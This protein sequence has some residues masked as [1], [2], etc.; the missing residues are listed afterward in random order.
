ML[1]QVYSIDYRRTGF[2]CDN[3]IIANAIFLYVRKIRTQFCHREDYTGVKVAIVLGRHFVHVA[4]PGKTRRTLYSTQFN[5]KTRKCNTFT[6]QLKPVLRY[7]HYLL[8]YVKPLLC[9][10]ANS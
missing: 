1:E 4:C 3:L 5:F 8:N 7:L 6:L 10:Q 9:L 2:N